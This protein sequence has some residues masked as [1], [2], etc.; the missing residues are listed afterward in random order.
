MEFVRY[1]PESGFQTV[2]CPLFPAYFFREEPG[3][4]PGRVVKSGEGMWGCLFS[5][6]PSSLPSEVEHDRAT[7]R[8]QKV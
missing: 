1:M 4:D 7:V 5:G 6:L 8:R 2:A 3:F